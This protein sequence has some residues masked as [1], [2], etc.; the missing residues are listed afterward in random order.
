MSTTDPEFPEPSSP[1]SF[2]STQEN[3]ETD[4]NNSSTSSTSSTFSTTSTFNEDDIK[5]VSTSVISSNNHLSLH[6]ICNIIQKS[7]PAVRSQKLEND[8]TSQY[9]TD[10]IPDNVNGSVTLTD[11]VHYNE[12]N[13]IYQTN[14]KPIYGQNFHPT[15]MLS[16]IPSGDSRDRESTICTNP[17]CLQC[18]YTTTP[19]HTNLPY[20]V[21][22]GTLPFP[23]QYYYSLPN[24]AIYSTCVPPSSVHIQ[25]QQALKSD[26]PDPQSKNYINVE[27]DCSE[28]TTKT[29]KR[30]RRKSKADLNSDY[31]ENEPTTRSGEIYRC[32]NCG[33]RET[34]A[35]RRDLRGEAL[36]C[37]ACGL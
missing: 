20:P 34:P 24:N 32:S 7:S 1:R 18:R 26:T 16:I 33:A 28:C 6:N 15:T 35:W 9:E 22:S 13:S 3:Y 31:Y 21:V 10:A 11:N 12:P 30:H 2:S 27:S 23:V 4:S 29:K 37:N 14:S 8:F 5:S 17:F 19:Y 36:L 25:Q